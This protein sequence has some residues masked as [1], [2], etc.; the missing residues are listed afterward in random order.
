[1]AGRGVSA[2]FSAVIIATVFTVCNAGTALLPSYP[3]AVKSPYLSTWL[4][5]NQISNAASAEPQFWAG[6]TLT[7]VKLS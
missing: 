6:Q 3:L 4:P 1:M 7:W 2:V 5:G